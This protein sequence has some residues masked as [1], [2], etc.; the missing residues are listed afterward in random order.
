MV[1]QILRSEL[2]MR[3][4]RHTHTVE[5]QCDAS[6]RTV[7][8]IEVP[9]RVHKLLPVKIHLTVVTSNKTIDWNISDQDKLSKDN[10]VLDVN[11]WERHFVFTGTLNH[12]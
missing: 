12:L 3:E 11:F 10:C 8:C 7:H 1:K 5:D 6:L 4:N 2:P 9:N